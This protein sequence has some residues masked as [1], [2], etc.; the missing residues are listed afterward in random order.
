MNKTL[1]KLTIIGSM[2]FLLAGCN[3]KETVDDI[4][5]KAIDR[6]QSLMS[7]D[8]EKAY[9][10]LAPSYRQLENLSSFSNRMNTAQLHITWNEVNFK[11]KQC[12]PEVCEVNI[13]M[14]YTYKFPKRS[15]GE[16]KAT[17]QVKESWIKSN[18][19]WYY[20]PAEKKGI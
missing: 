15:M 10:F 16:S 11:N 1:L 9:S 14:T 17:T 2:L 18:D 5:K 7:G 3:T 8:Y 12:E 4:D 19:K 20:L 6:W 13:D